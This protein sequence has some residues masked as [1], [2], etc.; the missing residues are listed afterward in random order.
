[1]YFLEQNQ[2]DRTAREIDPSLLL[3]DSIGVLADACKERVQI[4]DNG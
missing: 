2:V 3:L 1:M 4:D